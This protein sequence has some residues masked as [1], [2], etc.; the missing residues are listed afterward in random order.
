MTHVLRI[1]AALAGAPHQHVIV[2]TGQRYGARLSD[3]F[4]S[5][6]G[7]PDPD[8]HHGVGSGGHGKQT[9]AVLAAMDKVLE[10]E[11]PD[12]VPEEHPLWTGDSGLDKQ[13][14]AD[15]LVRAAYLAVEA[16]D[17]QRA[18][19]RAHADKFTARPAALL[20]AVDPGDTRVV[21]RLH[22][23]ET[24]SPWPFLVDFTRVD[25]LVFV[26]THLRDLA[27]S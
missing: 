20:I 27:R 3:V 22:S 7:I 24:F 1:A 5:G 18:A 11:K 10:A 6:L 16:T 12:R 14:L 2:H 26:G 4:F 9:G 17:E 13:R 19:A 23:A 25:D 8:F 15:S 21:M